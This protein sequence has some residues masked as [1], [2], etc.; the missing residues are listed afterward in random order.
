MPTQIRG[1]KRAGAGKP[2]TPDIQTAAHLAD[3]M[4]YHGQ[5]HLHRKRNAR[6]KCGHVW[7]LAYRNTFRCGTDQ[8]LKVPTTATAPTRH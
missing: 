2:A 4:R 6:Y 8:C 3:H 5:L 1:G 7:E